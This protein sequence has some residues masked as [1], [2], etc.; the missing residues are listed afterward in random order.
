MSSEEQA[1]ENDWR[2]RKRRK[3]RERILDAARDLFLT[4]G[5]TA[6]SVEQ[7]AAHADVGPATVYN[8]FGSKAAI[9]AYLFKDVFESLLSAAQAD[10]EAHIPVEQAVL[11]HFEL[12][13]QLAINEHMV[14]DVFFRGLLET[15][16]KGDYADPAAN[17]RQIVS[18]HTPLTTIL[19]AGKARGE[20][21]A[22]L[23]TRDA[24][25][26]GLNPF[27]VKLIAGSEPIEAAHTVAQMLLYGVFGPERKEKKEP[28]NEFKHN[29]Q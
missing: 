11:R 17:P 27:I 19:E 12:F 1:Q 5:Y 15:G 26:M 21:P 20:I 29:H 2:L 28:E 16:L 14:V 23:D 8:H 10:V 4:H 3:P 7:I 6:V 18:L 13:A 25:G 24:A 9:A 22:Q